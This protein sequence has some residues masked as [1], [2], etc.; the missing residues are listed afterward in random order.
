MSCWLCEVGLPKYSDRRRIFSKDGAVAVVLEGILLQIGSISQAESGFLQQSTL[1]CRP[2]FGDVER[3]TKLRHDVKE[4]EESI[5][6]KVKRV[7]EGY[8]VLVPT[9]V[10]T[11]EISVIPREPSSPQQGQQHSPSHCS[12][13]TILSKPV[14][15]QIQ[16]DPSSSARQEKGVQTDP[17]GV[18]VS[19]G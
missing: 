13:S 11:S 6:Q 10:N 12:S 19:K 1:L 17:S 2:C 15:P 5:R 9:G 4:K 14:G 7:L 3:L 8:N 18:E 16:D